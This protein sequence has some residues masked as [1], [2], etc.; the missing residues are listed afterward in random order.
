[1]DGTH[2]DLRG[3]AMDPEAKA[4]RL[5]RFIGSVAADDA[6]MQVFWRQRSAA[7]HAQA[8]AQLSDVAS[9]MAT[10]TGFGKDPAEMFPGL[11]SFQRA[12]GRPGS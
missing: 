6:E 11:S 1:M 8:G 2:P 9:Q 5:R 3:L 4:A 7:E 10:Q 12:R